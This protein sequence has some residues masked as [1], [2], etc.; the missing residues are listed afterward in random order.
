MSSKLHVVPDTTIVRFIVD[1]GMAK[2]LAEARRLIAQGAVFLEGKRVGNDLFHLRD[3]DVVH[4]G[5]TKWA[6]FNT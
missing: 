2:S 6:I 5:K 4:V 3:G 1:S